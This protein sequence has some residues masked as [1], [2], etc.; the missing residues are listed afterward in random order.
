MGLAEAEGEDRAV[1]AVREA[2][3]SPLLNDNDIRGAKFVLLNVALGS[4]DISMDEMSEITDHIQEAAGSNADVI[5]GY[6]RD[7]SL[8]ERIRVS[9]IATGFNLNSDGTPRTEAKPEK[10]RID[11]ESPQPVT[12]PLAN[13]FAGLSTSFSAPPAAPRPDPLEPFI[14]PVEPAAVAKEETP[15]APVQQAPP[16]P[17]PPPAPVRQRTIEFEVDQRPQPT[18]SV[19]VVNT[20]ASTPPAPPA[21]EKVTHELYEEPAPRAAAPSPAPQAQEPRVSP[22]EHS[23]RVDERLSRM[24]EMSL[25]I[26]STNGV[27]DLER[28][29]AYRRKNVT[30]S[31]VPHSS[32]SSVSRYTL[33]EETDENGER[34]VELRR[35]NPFLH[36]NV[37]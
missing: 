21:E 19:P 27:A 36:D 29:P 5:W 24:R 11:L 33:N 20:T 37:D 25:R 8:G 16:A 3:A 14:K 9:V 18:A 7:E 6:C 30:L 26:R 35:N 22:V 34:R 10:V 32:D 12:A 4:S 13:P 23:L 15:A 31:D 1:R 2:L 28:E 17:V